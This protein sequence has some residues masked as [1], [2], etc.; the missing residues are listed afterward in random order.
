[1]VS[2]PLRPHPIP[3]R[4]GHARRHGRR[5]VPRWWPPPAHRPPCAPS[6]GTFDGNVSAQPLPFRAADIRLQATV[7]LELMAL[8]QR[9]P[10]PRMPNGSRPT[11]PSAP[12]PRKG[13]A[14]PSSEGQHGGKGAGDHEWLHASS[15]KRP[16]GSADLMTMKWLWHASGSQRTHRARAREESHRWADP[17]PPGGRGPCRRQLCGG[18]AVRPPLPR[19]GGQEPARWP[20]HIK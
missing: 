10:G 19:P 2:S 3:R 17:K 6:I 9:P 1:V 12:P 14:R 15:A 18:R 8:A 4:L 5:P 16:H 7:A 20:F 11:I 13:G